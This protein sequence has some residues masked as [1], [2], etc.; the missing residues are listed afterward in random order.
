MK[1]LLF[2]FLMPSLLLSAHALFSQDY[3]IQLRSTLDFPGQTLANVCGYTQNGHEYALV[4]A[5]LGLAIVDITNPDAP[6]LIVQI[7]GPNDLW[8]EIKTYQHYAYVT[9][10]GGLGLQIVDLSQ[11]PSPNLDHYYYTGDGVIEGQL[12]KIHA[13]HVDTTQGFLYLY[14][15]QLYSGGAKVFD[16]N[17]NP[18]APQFVGKFDQLN[19]VHDG[20]VDNDTLYACHISDG[21]LSIV[22]MHDKS[23]PELLGTVETPARFTHNSW[24]LSD[25]KHILTT[26]EKLPSFVTAYDISDPSDIQE[27]DRIATTADGNTSIGHNTHVLNDW[28]ITS[29][30][31]DGV[32]LIDAHRPNNL[33]QVGRYDTYS[34][35][36]EF[37][38]C[39]GVYPF[40]PSGNMVAS[41]IPNIAN[42]VTGKLF[43][44]TPTYV[45]ACYLEGN[46]KSSCTGQGLKDVSVTINSSDPLA[47]TKTSN[48]G[49]Y[50]TGQPTPGTFT[51][52]FSKPGF[53]SK[54][55]TVVLATA[56]VTEVSLILEPISAFT[57]TG[58]VVDAETGLPIPNIP[59]TLQSPLQ[60]YQ[61][62][63]DATGIFQLECAPGGTYQ[64]KVAE[65][66]FLPVQFDLQE[67]GFVVIPIQH[68]YYDDFGNNLNWT[69]SSNATSGN[70]VRADPI[71]TTY[72]NSQCAPE[73]DVDFDDNAQCYVTGNGNGNAGDHDVDGGAVTLSTP[74]MQLAEYDDAILTFQYWFF[75]AGGTSSPNDIFR[76]MVTNGTSEVQVFSDQSTASSWA[77]S[78]EIHLGGLIPLTDDM[79]VHFIA[80]D[81]DPGHLVEGGVDV[82]QVRPISVVNTQHPDELPSTL[83]VNPNP[84]ARGFNVQY[85]FSGQRGLTLE[86]RNA[87]GQTVFSQQ[88]DSE[89]GTIQCGEQWPKGLYFATLK[90]A[91]RQSA[92]LKM[93]KQ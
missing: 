52:T 16:L 71:G 17:P 22:D 25:K 38:G 14:G 48:N 69:A 44:L 65:W 77:S 42:N 33:V 1:K 60:S 3:N 21:Y 30:Y 50:K 86:V 7:P 24:L 92:P 80:E 82:F 58:I 47:F 74:T 23:N 20:Y 53:I 81:I 68:G 35:Q 73:N 87:L 62:Q 15:G 56:Q 36:G 66:G 51:V 27:L 55:L 79:K 84:T 4:G 85:D 45:R 78:G 5:S 34:G 18:F 32:T 70:W 54:T 76:V 59:V 67:N 91:Q 12:D 64:V 11:L 57:T 63:S 89:S 19:Y 72:V 37:D 28:A 83:S 43:V 10:E 31:I 8:K 39:W 9:S 49:D 40:F 26:D 6:V 90:N 61:L 46:V 41:N 88:L 93:L 2:T 29:W 13:L 75:N